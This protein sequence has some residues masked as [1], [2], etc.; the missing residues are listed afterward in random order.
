[1]FAFLLWLTPTQ[2][3]QSP[4]S[5][6][7]F[8]ASEVVSGPELRGSLV[9]RHNGPGWTARIGGSAASAPAGGDPVLLRFADGRGEVRIRAPKAGRMRAFWIQPPGALLGSPYA[10]P[11]YQYI[12][13]LGLKYE[14]GTHYASSSGG[15]NLALGMVGRAS[16]LWLPEFFDRHLAAPLQIDHYGINLTPAGDAYGGGGVRLRP[17]DLLKFGQTYL[18]GGRWN[19]RRIVSA[20]WVRA[21]VR[22]QTDTPSGSDGYAW[23]R[24]RLNAGGQDYDEFEANGNGGQFLIVLPELDMTVVF[25]AGNYMQYGIWHNFREELTTEYLIAAVT[26]R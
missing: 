24:F 22:H 6:V 21:S 23:H 20:G 5:L 9:L 14:P 19:G 13:A 2:T 17:R 8:W 10:T 4:D 12:L 11:W 3:P 16:G 26:D 15:M 1:M 7:G 18:A 25:T